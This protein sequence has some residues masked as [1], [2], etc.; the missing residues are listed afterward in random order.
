[1]I[2]KFKMKILAGNISS[3]LQFRLRKFPHS[4]SKNAVFK[5]IQNCHVSMSRV[6]KFISKL[7][8]R[9]LHE[10]N[11]W[12]NLCFLLFS[13]TSKVF[14][15]TCICKNSIILD[16]SPKYEKYICDSIYHCQQSFLYQ[17]RYSVLSISSG[18]LS[19]F[20]WMVFLLLF[21]LIYLFIES[22]PRGKFVWWCCF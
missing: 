9:Y 5:V 21:F 12:K 18:A 17:L 6:S 15:N 16:I 10:I 14:K 11:Q 2:S 19:S 3:Y 4:S 8:W 22:T 1:M 13:S 20:Y 7:P